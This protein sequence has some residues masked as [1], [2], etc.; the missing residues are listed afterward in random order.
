VQSVAN[1]QHVSKPCLKTR[2]FFGFFF[3]ACFIGEII[4]LGTSWGNGKV[5]Y[6]SLDD[7][8]NCVVGN[9]GLKQ[10]KFN[11]SAEKFLMLKHFGFFE[12]VVRA[13]CVN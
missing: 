9:F 1:Y 13:F 2:A 8:L 6:Q 12:L 11:F 4:N 3:L 5:G 7:L 10:S